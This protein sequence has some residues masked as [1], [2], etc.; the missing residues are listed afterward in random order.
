MISEEGEICVEVPVVEMVLG[1]LKPQELPVRIAQV[2][3]VVGGQDKADLVTISKMFS[4]FFFCVS[5][6]Q[7]FL[8]RGGLIRR[9]MKVPGEII[10]I[11]TGRKSM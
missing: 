9:P 10:T 11:C 2:A 1:P 8:S 3:G 7:V 4:F 5:S 6:H